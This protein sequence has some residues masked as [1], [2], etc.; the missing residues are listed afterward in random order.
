M[1]GGL[2][3][4]EEIK[5]RYPEQWLLIVDYESDELTR[6]VRGVLTEHSRHR[7]DIYEKLSQY[8]GSVCIDYAGD[9][10][11][12]KMRRNPMATERERKLFA[13]F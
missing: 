12:P 8:K 6:P 13:P 9:V 2:E 1:K 4:I 7:S 10:L 3:S 5:K 11:M